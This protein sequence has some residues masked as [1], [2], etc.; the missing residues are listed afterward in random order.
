MALMMTAISFVTSFHCC[1]EINPINQ[2][3][4]LNKINRHR[5]APMFRLHELP[6]LALG[7]R[8]SDRR[9]R[10]EAIVPIQRARARPS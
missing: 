6:F 2:R 3:R 5:C 1:L 9:E 7:A 4:F 8:T 10:D